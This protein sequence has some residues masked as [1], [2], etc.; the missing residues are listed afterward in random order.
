M[1]WH[2]S[3]LHLTKV[4]A[5]LCSKKNKLAKKLAYSFSQHCTVWDPGALQSKNR[6]CATL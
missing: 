1:F 6:T 4:V 5:L 2:L 3:L